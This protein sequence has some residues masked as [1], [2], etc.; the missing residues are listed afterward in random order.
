ME[1]LNRTWALIR[2]FF[3]VTRHVPNERLEITMLSPRGMYTLAP[4]R[5][6]EENCT[7]EL[8]CTARIHPV[9]V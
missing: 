7:M 3:R 5:T 2:I 9:C 6:K 8:L 1:F 4:T